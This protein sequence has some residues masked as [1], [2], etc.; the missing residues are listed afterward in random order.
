YVAG[1]RPDIRVP[2]REV[3][4]DDPATPAVRLYD[5]SGP[6]TDPDAQIDIRSGLPA[7]RARWIDERGDTEPTDAAAP[8]SGVAPALSRQPR[9]ARLGAAV[10][11]LHYARKGIVTPEM[12]F[13]AIREGLA[14]EFV[15]DE[16]ARGRAILPANINHPESE[17][18]AIGRN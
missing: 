8:V 2:F 11:Q 4:V 3:H 9:R 5:T 17:P 13:V 1:S 6:Y 14:P 10:T 18:M 7:L 15:R 12:E 16:I